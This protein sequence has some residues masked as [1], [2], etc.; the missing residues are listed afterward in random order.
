MEFNQRKANRTLLSRLKMSAS[1]CPV[2]SENDLRFE[3]RVTGRVAEESDLAAL[4]DYFDG[5]YL[6]V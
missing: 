5:L 3:C 6:V 4:G 1:V 2:S